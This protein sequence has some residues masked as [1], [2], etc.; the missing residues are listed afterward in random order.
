MSAWFRLRRRTSAAGCEDAL[1]RWM[2]RPQLSRVGTNWRRPSEAFR[3]LQGATFPSLIRERFAPVLTLIE[4][5]VVFRQLRSP[6]IH[7]LRGRARFYSGPSPIPRPRRNP[8]R[9]GGAPRIE[10]ART[11]RLRP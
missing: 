8:G 10:T 6:A 9:R 11:W 3:A 2:E 5:D 7:S 1:G 4:R